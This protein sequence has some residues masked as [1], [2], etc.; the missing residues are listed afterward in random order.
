MT[1]AT[2]VAPGVGMSVSLSAV[3]ANATFVVPAGYALREIYLKNKTANAVTGGLRLGTTNG[4][5]DVMVALAL[6]NAAFVKAGAAILL[7]TFSSTVDTTL[8]LQAVAAW[9]GASIDIV[10]VLDRAVP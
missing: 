5:V 2:T 6:G 9:N 3:I 7:N 4:G 10:A 8:Y 1:K